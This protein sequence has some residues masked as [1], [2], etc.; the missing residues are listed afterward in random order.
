MNVE[1]ILQLKVADV[2][3]MT[4]QQIDEILAPLIPAARKPDEEFKSAED[5]KKLMRE[6]AALRK[7]A[8]R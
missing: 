2:E 7:A 6:I 1:E 4:Q 8:A 5:T 3:K